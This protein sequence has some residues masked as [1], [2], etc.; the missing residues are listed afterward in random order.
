[1]PNS[2]PISTISDSLLIPDTIGVVL[3]HGKT[4]KSAPPISEK[5]SR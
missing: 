5:S 4:V 3:G 2:A 1:M